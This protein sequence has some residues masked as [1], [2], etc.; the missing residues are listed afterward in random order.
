MTATYPNNDDTQF[1]RLVDGE[2]SATERQELLTS[3]DSRE[4][5][6]R[7]CALAFLEAQ[8]WSGEF[9]QMLA[10]PADSPQ[11]VSLPG[12]TSAVPTGRWLAIAAGLL[13]AFGVGW[14]TNSAPRDRPMDQQ[15]TLAHTDPQEL[16][17][18]E[19]FPEGP[20]EAVDP[21]D[22]VT[23]LVRDVSGNDQR[24]QVPLM[25]VEALNDQ[26]ADALPAELRN[27]FRNRGFDVQ[28]RRRFAPMFFE[29]NEQ[30]VPMIV[31]VDDTKIVPVSRPIF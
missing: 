29:Q 17:E 27:R 22:A 19:E 14:L 24:V 8:A 3:L 26:F 10:D 1:D 25:E 4:D 21:N 6:W 13:I 2:L 12:D 5:G 20:R 16:V 11:V 7:R 28:R 31:P 30:L 15:T 23:L 9:K 18:P